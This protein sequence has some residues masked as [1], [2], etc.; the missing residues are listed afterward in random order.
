MAGKGKRK[1]KKREETG[2]EKYNGKHKSKDINNIIIIN[3]LNIFIKVR[4]WQ[5]GFKKR[6]K[7]MLFKE[8][9]F[10]YNAIGRK[11]VKGWEVL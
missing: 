10:K 3:G 9:H 1:L 4:K 5:T 11:K 8:I 7:Y 2:S 6:S